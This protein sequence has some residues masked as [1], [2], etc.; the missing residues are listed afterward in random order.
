M[1]NSISN[2]EGTGCVNFGLNGKINT[3]YNTDKY[4]SQLL[5]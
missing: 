2:M 4:F 3:L 1:T 5:A